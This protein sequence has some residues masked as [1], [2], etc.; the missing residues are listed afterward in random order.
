MAGL[1]RE[2]GIS[3]KTGYKILTRYNEIGLEGLTDRSRRPYRHAN[4]RLGQR[5]PILI[6]LIRLRF[7]HQVAGPRILTFE[8]LISRTPAY[9]PE[10]LS[11]RRTK[12]RRPPRTIM[13]L[14]E[15]ARP[16][17]AASAL[18]SSDRSPIKGSAA[19]VLIRS[20]RPL[21]EPRHS[22]FQSAFPAHCWCHRA[23]FQSDV[24]HAMLSLSL[25][26][27]AAR[28]GSDNLVS[29]TSGIASHVQSSTWRESLE[30]ISCTSIARE[31]KYR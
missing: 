14:T 30:P 5:R 15:S 29:R 9:S 22:F 8:K 7:S 21:A 27:F 17:E 25:A 28:L 4:S 3:R 13:V 31:E 24:A 16:R 26:R 1:C 12:A 2:F 23:P 20:P 11:G 10:M 6:H 18:G 19:R